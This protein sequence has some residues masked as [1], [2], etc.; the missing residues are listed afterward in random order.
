MV[1]VCEG[2][3]VHA[4]PVCADDGVGLQTE[5]DG[6]RDGAEGGH[7]P[8]H[9]QQPPGAVDGGTVRDWEHYGAESE[10]NTCYINKN[11]FS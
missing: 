6:L 9:H 2:D 7:A 5:H 11:Y 10:E 4:L 1:L 8:G 3:G